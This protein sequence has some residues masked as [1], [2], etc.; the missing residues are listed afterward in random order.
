V[1]ICTKALQGTKVEL[2][3]CDVGG[4]WC[5]VRASLWGHSLSIGSIYV[6]TH[7][8]ELTLDAI[9]E[10]IL[11]NGTSSSVIGGDFNLDTLKEN[12]SVLLK[13][14]DSNNLSLVE[15]GYP[16]FGGKSIIDH[17]VLGSIFDSYVCDLEVRIG[18]GLDHSILCLDMK[19]GN[20]KKVKFP[21]IRLDPE[22]CKSASIHK[23]ALLRMAPY[24]DQNPFEYLQ[25]FGRNVRH[26]ITTNVKL[27][28]DDFN[29][30]SLGYL[31]S[32]LGT[33]GPD[34]VPMSA[35]DNEFVIEIARTFNGLCFL[36]AR[37]ARRKWRSLV[38]H[39]I[40][41][42]RDNFGVKVKHLFPSKVKLRRWKFRR[43]YKL[44]TSEGH[45]YEDESD[46]ETALGEFW[47]GILGEERPYNSDLLMGLLKN[48]PRLYS[49]NEN[50]YS[51]NRGKL[52]KVFTSCGDTAA[53]YDGNPFSLFISSFE[54]LEEVWVDLIDG[55]GNGTISLNDD[56]GCSLLSLIA[57]ADGNIETKDF[58][59]ISVT[60]VI[61][62]IIMKYFAKEIR[63]L[64]EPLISVSQRALLK[65]RSIISATRHIL[66]TWYNRLW[67]NKD[68]VFLKTDFSKAFDFFNRDALLA[69]LDYYNLP[70]FVLNVAKVA[71]KNSETHVLGYSDS[72]NFMSVTG[73]RQGCPVSPLFYILGV[74]LLASNL[75]KTEGVVAF[76]CY[77][78]DNGL[79]LEDHKALNRIWRTI[80]IY[81]KS[82]VVS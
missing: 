20:I 3:S 16:T 61:Y 66:D 75:M 47:K 82:V 37:A 56:F 24:T 57:K 7:I 73:V 13:W 54:L 1:G 9:Q 4:R 43:K 45:I 69:I 78:D 41:D 23:E 60:N 44:I 21:N 27:I 74:D 22:V 5:F 38:R 35:R 34:Q 30:E 25:E 11:S 40:I 55:I 36:S 67:N 33:N 48:H 58:R 72:V 62:R 12:S 2:T 71:L 42:F 26:I 64:A 76:G 8:E 15:N 59:P 81:C 6:P 51:T 28:D 80:D 39:G 18:N 52:R 77:A 49:C 19:W 63:R 10:N 17:M 70:P 29:R 68:T 50:C 46:A 53:G 65:G 79:V 14:C 32:L 31:V